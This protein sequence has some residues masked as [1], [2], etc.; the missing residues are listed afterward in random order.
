M[1]GAW[2]V[3]MNAKKTRPTVNEIYELLKRS[4]LP[5]VLVEGKD[6]I[7][8]YRGIEFELSCFNIDM[9]PAGNKSSVSE[10]K[11]KIEKNH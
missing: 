8:F 9:L 4:S 10:F 3:T 6:D 11:S 2:R 1:G 7:I 5:T